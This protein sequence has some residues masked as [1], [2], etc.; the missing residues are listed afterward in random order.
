MKKAYAKSNC[1]L[2]IQLYSFDFGLFSHYKINKLA[3]YI[4]TESFNKIFLNQIQLFEDKAINANSKF[5]YK[6][7]DTKKFYLIDAG[8]SNMDE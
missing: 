7:Q 4:L 2:F 8:Q 1:Y 6:G 3:V 5:H